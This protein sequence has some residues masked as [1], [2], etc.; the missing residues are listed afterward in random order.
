[1]N[2]VY[3]DTQIF[4][5]TTL[6]SIF[7]AGPTSR[8]DTPSWRPDAV[9]VFEQMKFEGTLILPERKEAG[10]QIEYDDQ[11][12]WEWTHL[13]AAT[14][15]MFWVPRKLDVWPA[16]TTNV[17]FGRYVSVR[18]ER[19][20]YGRPE[21]SAKNRYLDWL[22]QKAAGRVPK[23]TLEETINEAISRTHQLW[24]VGQSSISQ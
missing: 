10:V 24:D 21:G 7:L 13:H 3:V 16:F 6:P 11:V 18:P 8:D 14:V 17:E 15:I 19:C 20:V 4:D 23:C 22:F 12:E 1:V 2:L 5:V 9:A